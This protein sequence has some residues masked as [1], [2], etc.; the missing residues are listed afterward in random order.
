MVFNVQVRR[1]CAVQTSLCYVCRFVDNQVNARKYVRIP[2]Y[3]PGLTFVFV[4]NRYGIG[5][6]RY[7]LL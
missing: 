6:Y 1:I 5:I 2:I 3:I 7:P 4:K